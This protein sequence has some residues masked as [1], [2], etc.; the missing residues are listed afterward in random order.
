MVSR[1]YG[2]LAKM[3]DPMRKAAVSVAMKR[4]N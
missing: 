4:Q 2:H 1:V 3:D